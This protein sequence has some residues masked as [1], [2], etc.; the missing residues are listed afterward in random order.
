M[1]DDSDRMTSFEHL[2][3]ILD[4]QDAKIQTL[5]Y[6]MNEVWT[7]ALVK[8]EPDAGALGQMLIAEMNRRSANQV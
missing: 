4:I 5:R 6:A 2:T 3:S 8:R 1:G 7:Y